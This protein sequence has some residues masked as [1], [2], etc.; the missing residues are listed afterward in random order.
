VVEKAPLLLSGISGITTWRAQSAHSAVESL[1]FLP[2]PLR[3]MN[4]L[5]S[6]DLYV[7]KAIW[8]SDL[9][10]LYPHPGFTL[11]P[12][13]A[14]VAGAALAAVTA[15]SLLQAR[16]RYSRCPWRPL[17]RRARGATISRCSHTPSRPPAR[18]G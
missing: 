12:A 1:E 13:G 4:A 7:V 2:L 16:R 8:P 11:A 14:I 6:Y 15:G 18:T 17:S 10:V 5:E 3:V 9:A